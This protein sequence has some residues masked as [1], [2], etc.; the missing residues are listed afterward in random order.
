M[1]KEREAESTNDDKVVEV[2]DINF[3][4]DLT[5]EEVD[6]ILNVPNPEVNAVR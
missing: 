4:D 6:A 1:F 3:S 2:V 5:A